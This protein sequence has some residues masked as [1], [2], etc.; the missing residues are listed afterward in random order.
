MWG[1]STPRLPV[2]G[3]ALFYLLADLLDFVFVPLDKPCVIDT[4]AHTT[5]EKIAFPKGRQA[6]LKKL[7]LE[8]TV[9]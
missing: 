9:V 3:R 5:Y 2:A 1:V 7:I 6:S 8:D 4:L